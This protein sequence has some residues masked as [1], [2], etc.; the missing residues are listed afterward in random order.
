VAAGQKKQG[1]VKS[2][3]SCNLIQRLQVAVALIFFKIKCTGK[4]KFAFT[5]R[6]IHVRSY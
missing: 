1:Q 5:V 3:Y 6:M 2:L 4:I